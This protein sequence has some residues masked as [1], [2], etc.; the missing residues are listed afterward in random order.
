MANNGKM[1]GSNECTYSSSSSAGMLFIVSSDVKKADSAT[2]KLIRSH[3]MQGIKKKRRRFVKVQDT[4]SALPHVAPV[5]LEETME[6]C[7]P[8][9]PDRLGSD[10]SFLVC[11]D[12]IEASMLLNIVKG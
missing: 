8:P 4:P 11:A 7:A 5:M 6:T 12:E 1:A 2:R 3:A 10:L 9:L